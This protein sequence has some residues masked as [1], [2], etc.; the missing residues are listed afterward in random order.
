MKKEE[1][2][3]DL[4]RAIVD[5]DEEKGERAATKLIEEKI[6][7]IEGVKKGLS[8]GMKIIGEKFNRSEVYLPELMIAADIFNSVMEILKP[9]I[10]AES[11][12][13]VK[14]GTVVIGTERGKIRGMLGYSIKGA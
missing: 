5:L 6:N 1:I 12:D 8:N 13:K 7:P 2:F 4:I 9:H 11:L 3:E 14:R 10:S